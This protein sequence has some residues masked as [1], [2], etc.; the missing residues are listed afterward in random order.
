M[1]LAASLRKFKADRVQAL[2]ARIVRETVEE[3]SHQ[4]V[5]DWS[6]LGNPELWKS[7]PPA[8]YRPGNF[9][10]S[11]FLSIGAPS[12]ETTDA[13]TEREAHHMERLSDFRTGETINLS[14]SADHAGALNGGHSSQ[15]PVGITPVGTAE[16]GPMAYAVARRLSQ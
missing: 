13:T 12:F 8:N 9:R 6:P 5:T 14:N 1:S 11:W 15:A 7:T 2:P 10:S 4:L 3:F 16:F